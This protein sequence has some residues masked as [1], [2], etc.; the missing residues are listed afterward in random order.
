M[1]CFSRQ[2]WW[3]MRNQD[4]TK[5]SGTGPDNPLAMAAP[6]PMVIEP[7][8]FYPEHDAASLLGVSPDTLRRRRQTKSDLAFCRYGRRVFYRGADIIAFLE[9]SRRQSTSDVGQRSTRV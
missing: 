9:A 1:L 3:I 2:T 4:E 7:S 5:I 6:R 8:G